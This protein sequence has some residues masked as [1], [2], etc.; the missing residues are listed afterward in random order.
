MFV[1]LLLCDF[2]LLLLVFFLMK[3]RPTRSTRNDTL[4]PYT[5]LFPS[6]Q[7]Q[8]ALKQQ[9]DQAL[10]KPG[11][12][13]TEHGLGALAK[14]DPQAKLPADLRHALQRVPEIGRAH[15]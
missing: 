6:E 10:A 13:K 12:R 11:E 4:F 9:M 5:T 2:S 14:D 7:A 15:V 3:R 1:E 8:Q